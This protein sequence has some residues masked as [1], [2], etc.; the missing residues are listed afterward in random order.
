MGIGKYFITI[1]DFQST[2]I[3]EEDIMGT[4]ILSNSSSRIIKV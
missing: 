3:T 2:T 4:L 1:V